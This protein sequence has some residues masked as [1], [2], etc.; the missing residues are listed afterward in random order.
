M[1]PRSLHFGIELSQEFARLANSGRFNEIP[2]FR[3]LR[4]AILS[5]APHFL[6]AEFHGTQSRVTFDK[7][8]PWTKGIA[9]CEL[10]DLC[11]VW[12]NKGSQPSARITFLQAKRSKAKHLVCMA[13]NGLL[14]ESFIGDSTQWYLLH[15]RPNIVGCFRTFQPPPHLLKDALLAS[16]ATFCVFHKIAPQD[17]S[18]FYASADIVTALLPSKPGHVQL[19]AHAPITRILSNG[20][21]EQKA[22]CCP[23]LFG[24]ALFSGCIGTPIDGHSVTSIADGGWRRSVRQ[25]LGSVLSNQPRTNDINPVIRAFITT[26]DIPQDEAATISPAPSILFIQGDDEELLR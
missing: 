24:E 15:H 7:C 21:S 13:Q 8:P 26:F 16:V 4:K 14:N 11:I 12:F 20:F 25:W 19:T 6:V 3:A 23:M 17:Y 1:S 22:S 18:F 2:L 5:T 10:S 9:R